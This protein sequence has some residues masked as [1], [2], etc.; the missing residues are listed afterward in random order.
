[1]EPTVIDGDVTDLEHL[2]DSD[3]LPVWDKT[4]A[5]LMSPDESAPTKEPVP[6]ATPPAT[7]Q[8]PKT[9][10]TTIPEFR[11]YQADM[12]RK[13]AAEQ[14]ARR[15]VEERAAEIQRRADD[16]R[17]TLLKASL[18]NDNLEADQRQ[19][20]AEEFAALRG[21][22]YFN[23]MRRWEQYKVDT[24]RAEGLDPSDQRL[25]KKYEGELGAAQFKADLAQAALEQQ[26]LENKRLSALSDPAAVSKIVQAELAKLAQANGL[27]I[28]DVGGQGAGIGGSEDDMQRDINR[29]QMGQMDRRA[30]AKKWG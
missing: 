24:I 13:L 30:F 8:T 21:A 14:R 5:Q 6:Q 29:L 18:A 26:R 15:E 2:S 23:Q 16:E 1:M 4:N 17:A 7:D 3:T 28:A 22:S 10:L 9:D 11:K 20:I 25:N 27:N 19:Q 12:D